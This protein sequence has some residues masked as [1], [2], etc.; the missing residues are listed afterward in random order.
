MSGAVM[1]SLA[2]ILLCLT[3]AA[4]ADDA[5]EAHMMAYFERFNARDIDSIVSEIYAMPLQIGSAGT[6]RVLADE[7]AARSNLESLYRQLD[8]QRWARS[9]ISRVEVCVLADGLALADTIYA[10]IDRDG[11]A[12]P[13][14]V[15]TNVYIL[16]RQAEG[17][18]IVSFYG[19][20][21]DRPLGCDD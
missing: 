6:H 11:R 8:E 17:W 7:A 20:D 14:D 19:R 16:R 12:I 9:V 13:P 5:V 21:A 15:R 4:S 10:R 18:R 3:A 2:P 1:R